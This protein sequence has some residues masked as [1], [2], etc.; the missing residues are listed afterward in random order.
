MIIGIAVD[1]FNL[2]V[3]LDEADSGYVL[4]LMYV[5][6]PILKL[7]ADVG[8]VPR[9]RGAWINVAQEDD[10]LHHAPVM[11]LRIMRQIAMDGILVEIWLKRVGLD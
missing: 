5:K 11:D 8:M 4:S 6:L 2:A 10:S 3:S 7:D 9:F 1:D